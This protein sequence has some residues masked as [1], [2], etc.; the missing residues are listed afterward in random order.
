MTI[1]NLFLVLVIIGVVLWAITTFIPMP[2]AI[3]N[4][5][6]IVGVII[7]VIYVLSAFGI[8]SGLSGMRVPT[9]K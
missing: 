8:I 3:K 9:I 7:A 4:L 5:I 6:L 2:Q 1:I